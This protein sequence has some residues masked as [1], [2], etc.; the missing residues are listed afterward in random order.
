MECT[1]CT[2]AQ[3]YKEN[4]YKRKDHISAASKK[5]FTKRPPPFH[6]CCETGSGYGWIRNLH[7]KNCSEFSELPVFVSN[8]DPDKYQYRYRYE[9][10][11][12]IINQNF[13]NR[14][15]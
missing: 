10:K 7:F 14:C 2:L 5:E 1:Y 13:T 3:T 15:C 11:K 8:P 6:L 9:E 4:Q 12:I